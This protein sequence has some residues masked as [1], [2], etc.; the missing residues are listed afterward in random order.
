MARPSFAIDKTPRVGLKLVHEHL[1]DAIRII[2][3]IPRPAPFST[4][5]RD[6]IQNDKPQA[7]FT[8]FAQVIKTAR[9]TFPRSS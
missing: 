6:M 5:A 3:D 8:A 7:A 9:A 4:E 1:A 2:S